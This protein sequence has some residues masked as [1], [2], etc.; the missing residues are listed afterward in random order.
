MGVVYLAYDKER[1][2]QI[3][4]KT[5]AKVSAAA[6]YRFK[7]EF[8]GLSN[9]VHPN[10][11]ALHEL[12]SQGDQWFFTMEF[13]DGVSFLEFVRSDLGAPEEDVITAL[14]TIP[15][16]GEE[17]DGVD[18]TI[19]E[20]LTFPTV[21]RPGATKP[22]ALALRP[23]ARRP[24]GI[25][26]PLHLG[27]L[28]PTLKQLASGVLALHESGKLHRDIKPSNV[29]VTPAGRVVLLDFGLVVDV[30]EAGD[31]ELSLVGTA[32]YMSPE[33]AA[34][35]SLSHASDWYSV[36][37]MLYQALCGR[38]PFW[39]ENVDILEKKQRQ[40]PPPPRVLVPRV[41]SDL[42]A[43]CV[44]LLRMDP[45]DRPSGDEVIRRLDGAGDEPVTHAIHSEH[46]SPVFRPSWTAPPTITEV[47]PPGPSFIGR[48][49]D[50]A[51]LTTAFTDVSQ[52]RTVTA[53]VSGK[54][55]FG[56]SALVQR[57]IETISPRALVLSGRCYERESVPYKALD[58]IIDDLSQHLR[59]MKALE[60]KKLLPSGIAA[61]ARVFTVLRRIDAIAEAIRHERSAA[62]PQELRQN[63]FTAF[64][65]LL[66]NLAAER[67]LVLH[68]D[69]LQWGDVDSAN[70]LRDLLRPPDAPSMMFL[71]VYQAEYAEG[72]PMLETL[73]D[74]AS[75]AGSKV[76]D[77]RHLTIGPLT[78]YEA[79]DFALSLLGKTDEATRIH[80]E[81][82]A[83]ESG[84]SP[85]FVQELVRY[86]LA[87][88][89][90][91]LD[92]MTPSS[93]GMTLE[94]ALT[95]RLV[96]LPADALRL[97]EVVAV[98]GRPTD[99]TVASRASG[100]GPETRGALTLLRAGH[101]I[102]TVPAGDKERIETYHEA[103]GRAVLEGLDSRR[104]ASHHRELAKVLEDTG[105]ADAEI[106]ADHFAGAGDAETAGE[107]AAE[108][109]AQ[110][111][112]MLA[113]DRAVRLYR[114]ALAPCGADQPRY[115]ELS[116]A[117][118]DALVAAGRGAEAAKEY[119]TAADG[120][121]GGV[122]LELRRQAA[123]QL[124]RSGHRDHGLE[125]LESVLR[126]VDMELPKNVQWTLVSLIR[127]R[128]VIALRGY[129]FEE[130]DPD[131]IAPKVL[132]QIDVAWTAVIG[133]GFV[134]A[135][136]AADFQSRHL[137]FALKAGERG[138]VTRALATETIYAAAGGSKSE[139]RTQ[140]LVETIQGLAEGSADP[141]PVAMASIVAGVAAYLQGDF[142]S[143]QVD[144]EKGEEVLR[145]KCTGV[146][147][148]LASARIF[149]LSSLVWL[150]RLRDL[151]MLVPQF[152]REAEGRGDIYAA[153]VL[154][155]GTR[156]IAWLV[157]G[158]V[159]E[160]R[161]QVLEGRRNWDN[162]GFLLPHYFD[163]LAST[164]IELYQGDADAALT[165]IEQSWSEFEASNLT[166]IQFLRVEGLNLRG[167]AKL[168]VA[169]RARHKERLLKIVE[170]DAA[171]IE[172]ERLAWADPLAMMLRAG[173]AIAR[174]MSEEAADLLTS[175]AVGFDAANL[176][177]LANVA[178]RRLGE[179]VGG[180]EGR[181]RIEAADTWMRTEGIRE[182]SRMAALL[183]PF[184]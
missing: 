41:P 8:R 166:R 176:K 109:A 67:T 131:L 128:A 139:R 26:S 133:L 163:L 36:G 56:K 106:L 181:L 105:V 174:N 85:L 91:D 75:Y 70:V 28:R 141:Y 178:R 80:A 169:M 107:Y 84:G 46:P 68:I 88:S 30:A 155:S 126:A 164:Q 79:R 32:A 108:A 162:E 60:L 22:P 42:N 147:W 183:A 7:Q 134:D 173:V 95:M 52:G 115:R 121:T 136:R 104:L 153:T 4:L 114:L 2:E 149:S 177:L 43:L 151:G 35:H 66:K 140:K 6:I 161:R 77:V 58:P 158:D 97:L 15:S 40:E 124:L 71:A 63:A 81:A 38:L 12:I 1:G 101:L 50:F 45:G 54:S 179:L 94:Q 14:C 118:G 165:R 146:A 93:A 168:A 59:K 102:R 55:G 110:A 148:D 16:G 171:R 18:D 159:E 167:R 123:E 125:V 19:V 130:T 90:G 82:I 27:R 138:R 150:G 112:T 99:L 86:A 73:L 48:E 74:E 11:V 175:S 154:R 72:S 98:A 122:A 69:D 87:I 135:L 152:V 156:N 37:V 143:A 78:P 129:R 180:D 172:K 117:L 61:L 119:L 21:P 113:F 24:R 100:L 31:H 20:P 53:F 57:F 184:R 111:A 39:G 33:Q 92:A 47:S 17:V 137:L 89:E 49:R 44:D 127:R 132:T 144:L 10:L 96:Q 120:A 29:L 103:V 62:D 160:A 145:E 170:S 9:V 3:A 116:I 51:K 157:N 34:A 76:P 13:V 25:S 65:Q 142:A 182:P 83:I 5:L 23:S 64:R